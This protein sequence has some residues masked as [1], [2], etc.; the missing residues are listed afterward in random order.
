MTS[1]MVEWWTVGTVLAVLPAWLIVSSTSSPP[2]RLPLQPLQPIRPLDMTA[3]E[4]LSRLHSLQEG[5]A[6]SCPHAEG[7][8]IIFMN[9]QQL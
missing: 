1:A 7:L 6:D 2:C 5:I 9:T 3:S 4:S 8:M